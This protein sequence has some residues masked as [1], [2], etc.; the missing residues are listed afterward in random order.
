MVVISVW[1]CSLVICIDLTPL[2]SL[3]LS[4]AGRSAALLP[5]T[6]FSRF[7]DGELY[8]G[9][10]A[11]S[12]KSTSD[13]NAFSHGSGNFPLA[14]ELKFK[15]G[16]AIFRK[17]WVSAPAS[18]TSSDGLG[19]LYNARSCQ[20]CHIK[21]GRGHPPRGNWPDDNAISMFLK[22]SVRPSNDQQK[23]LLSQHRQLSIPEPTYGGQLQD[24]AV[25][26]HSAEGKMHIDY[27]EQ[28]IVLSD[29]EIVVLRKP[30]YS[31][32]SLGYGPLHPD[33]MISPRV[34]P[35]MPGLGLLEAIPEHQIDLLADPDD[36]NR[37]GI[38]GR[39]N[40][41]W[42]KQHNRIMLGRFGL[43]AGN[44]S[45]LQ[46]AVGAF[47][48]DIGISS[49]LAPTP[50]GD[51]TEKQHKCLNAPNGTSQKTDGH[52][53]SNELLGLV[54]FYAQNLAV[55]KRRI[56]DRQLVL[57]GKSQFYKI[58]CAGCHYPK[59]RTGVLKNNKHLEDQLIWPYTD[60]LLHDMGDGLAD[61]RPEGVA[62]G[63]EWRTAPLWGIGLTQT[64]SGHTY[65]LHDG[66]ARNIKEAILWHGGESK[67]SRDAFVNLTKEDREKL[68][69][70]VNSL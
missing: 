30:N 23:Q 32:R 51:C 45:V 2:Q 4:A 31:V 49:M 35:Q 47:A 60:L 34:A 50:S 57:E 43:K 52:E 53:I 44:P 61:G 8:P 11:T 70:F 58:G 9:G 29:G 55:P 48:G 66:R 19:P 15:L 65:F 62:T 69:A 37:D 56:A 24:L 46:Q 1:V 41:V 33:T 14:D 25:Q 18:T 27:V 13:N 10:A 12:K 59:F 17:L 54:T 21:D 39:P 5:T 7:E 26:G 38:S 63:R 36:K 42:S 64:V 20:R 22:L 16:N 28:K 6:D 40:L 67:S 3:Q 68:I